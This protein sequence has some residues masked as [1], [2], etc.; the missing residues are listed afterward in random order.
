M[1]TITT[2][3]KLFKLN[4]INV[5]MMTIYLPIAAYFI[6]FFMGSFGILLAAF[7]GLVAFMTDRNNLKAQG[8]FVPHWGWY[9]FLPVYLWKRQRN[10]GG[11]LVWFWA[12]LI[13]TFVTYV[14]SYGMVAAQHGY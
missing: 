5:Q 9:F 13:T 4:T 3:I 11:S 8:A 10:N 1:S 6:G 12:Y 14:I 2:D 7:L